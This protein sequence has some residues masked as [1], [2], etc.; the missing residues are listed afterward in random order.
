MKLLVI[1]LVGLFVLGLFVLTYYYDSPISTS[2]PINSVGY[3]TNL[4]NGYTGTCTL[5]GLTTIEVKGGLI[6]GCT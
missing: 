4:T 6:T 2:V 5:L 1:F 3:K